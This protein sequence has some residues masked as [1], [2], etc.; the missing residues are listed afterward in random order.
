MEDKI[1]DINVED[2]YD[3]DPLKE[4]F[5]K[6]KEKN[7]LYF[8]LALR[9]NITKEFFQFLK[10]QLIRNEL[11]NINISGRTRSSKSTDAGIIAM[12]VVDFLKYIKKMDKEFSIDETYIFNISQ[13][14]N[15]FDE[16]V[17]KFH[18]MYIIDEKKT[19]EAIQSGSMYEEGQVKD[20]DRIAAKYCI[21]RINIIGSYDDIENNAFYSLVTYGKNYK[22]FTNKLIVYT[23]EE[24]ERVPLG[25]IEI[26]IKRFLCEDILNDKVTDCIVCPKYSEDNFKKYN[27]LAQNKI[28]AFASCNLNKAKYERLKDANIKDVTEGNLEER[29][30][31]KIKLSYSFYKDKMYMGIKSKSQRKVYIQDNYHLYTNRRLTIQEIDEIC[32]RVDLIRDHFAKKKDTLQSYIAE[33]NSLIDGGDSDDRTESTPSSNPKEFII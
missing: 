12:W 2:R 18:D 4:I 9:K 5:Y 30:K 33:D 17:I 13:L 11:I 29:T 16:Q 14:L 27:D 6:L 10:R 19:Y 24:N 3:I 7:D 20:I 25:Y 32:D 8:A 21:H 1:F 28:V 26:P 22:T 31:I 23:R 15:K